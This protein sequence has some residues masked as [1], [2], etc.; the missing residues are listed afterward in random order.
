MDVERV[1]GHQIDLPVFIAFVWVFVTI[2]IEGSVQETELV[3][4]SGGFG[5]IGAIRLNK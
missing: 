2:Q 5:L 4:D 3:M 1:F